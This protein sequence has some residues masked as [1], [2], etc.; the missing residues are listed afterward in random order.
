L[1]AAGGVTL[2]EPSTYMIIDPRYTQLAAGLTG[3]SLGCMINTKPLSVSYT[4]SGWQSSGGMHFIS[5]NCRLANF[6]TKN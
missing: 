6:I 4:Y 2:A 1:Q 5:L 3:F